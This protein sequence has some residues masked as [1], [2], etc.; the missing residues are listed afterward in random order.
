M[1][2]YNRK[3][4]MDLPPGAL[5]R[6]GKP[7]YFGNLQIKAGSLETDFVCMDIG[8]WEAQDRGG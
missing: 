7:C 3:E 6:K 5:F 2:I 4:F 8:E 1:K